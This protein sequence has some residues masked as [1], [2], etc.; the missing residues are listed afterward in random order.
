MFWKDEVEEEGRGDKKTREFKTADD[1]HS[2][3]FVICLV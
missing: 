3:N 1:I 2:D